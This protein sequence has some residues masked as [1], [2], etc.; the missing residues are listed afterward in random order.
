MNAMST[1]AGLA[2]RKRISS[3]RAAEQAIEGSKSSPTKSWHELLSERAN[4]QPSCPDV[5]PPP[6]AQEGP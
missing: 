5:E 6:T 2:T 4:K 1:G 3:R